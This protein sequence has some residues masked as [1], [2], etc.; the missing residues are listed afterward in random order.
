MRSTAGWMVLGMCAL[1]FVACSKKS[2]GPAD[3]APEPSAT[4]SAA[5][6]ATAPPTAAA[7][8]ATPTHID[9]AKNFVQVGSYCQKMCA[10]DSVCPT[11]STCT[12]SQKADDGSNKTV[13]FCL[14][15]QPVPSATTKTG[16]VCNAPQKGLSN[17]SCAMPCSASTDCTAPLG[18]VCTGNGTSF[19]DNQPMKFCEEPKCAAGQAFDAM[20]AACAV[21]C[22]ADANCKAPSKCAALPTGGKK[23][24]RK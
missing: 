1:T 23:V 3:A 14:S 2:E 12:G 8:A 21:I 5:P 22:T 7:T 4:A 18:W 11:G 17:G 9:C 13:R 15:T 19:G 16:P 24:C 20:A 6:S 10:D